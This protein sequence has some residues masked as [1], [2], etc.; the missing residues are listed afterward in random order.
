LCQ[1]L[2]QRSGS[3]SCTCIAGFVRS[4][5]NEEGFC[6]P[7][8]N[9]TFYN[10]SGACEE[11]PL[12]S[13]TDVPN[14]TEACTPCPTNSYTLQ[15]R[16]NSSLLC[17]CDAGYARVSKEE[18][19]ACAPGSFRPDSSAPGKPCDL[20]PINTYLPETASLGPCIP[21]INL[22]TTLGFTGKSDARD[23]VCNPGYY[24][25]GNASCDVCPP[26]FFCPGGIHPFLCPFSS[27]SLG[28]STNI[29]ACICIP[30]Y[31][32][33]DGICVICPP[34]HY[35]AG[36]DS[37]L[38]C[39][40]NSFSLEGSLSS[41]NCTCRSGFLQ[42]FVVCPEGTYGRGL[43]DCKPCPAGTYNNLTD[44]RQC[45]SCPILKP[46]SPLSS[47]SILRCDCSRLEGACACPTGTYGTRYPDCTLCPGN[48]YSDALNQ[49]ECTT[50]PVLRGVSAPGS[51]SI[52]ECGCQ[53]GTY[54]I[55]GSSTPCQPCPDDKPYSPPGAQFI[56]QCGCPEGFVSVSDGCVSCQNS[57]QP[58]PCPA[59][60]PLSVPFMVSDT[61][62]FPCADGSNS[63]EDALL[64]TTVVVNMTL[65][66]N[67]TQNFTDTCSC[68]ALYIPTSDGCVVCG[69][70]VA[71]VPCPAPFPFSPVG[72]TSISQCSSRSV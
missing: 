27:V 26:G 34:N 71:P 10:A 14:Q 25:S 3:I 4:Y 8:P 17:Y 69:Q 1:L 45:S 18:C 40:N 6:V 30:G 24:G 72:S 29:S 31:Y 49:T 68:P 67:S 23:C 52:L 53:A 59:D 33:R 66:G 62:C 20:C 55:V 7:C 61:Y 37:I 64:N 9:G 19:R 32:G 65:P 63:T 43:G 38:P 60:R 50:C 36:G 16:S 58:V 22:T 42:N 57:I 46:V 41:D 47:T 28:G 11:C 21:C 54:G 13:Y 35:C 2:G 44:Q 56:E 70:A 5:S 39:A 51:K 15:T 12:G 48:T